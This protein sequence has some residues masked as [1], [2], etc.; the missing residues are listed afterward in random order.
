MKIILFLFLSFN[1]FAQKAA[2]LNYDQKTFDS[3]SCCWRKLSKAREFERSANLIV[4][5]L[6]NGNPSNRQS[7]NWHAGQMFAFVGDNQQALKYMDKTYNVF[8]KWFGGEDGKTWYYFAK[9]TSAFIK[10]D[11]SKLE[12]IINRWK[13]KFPVD[14]NFNELILLLKNWDLNYE[15]AT[16]KPQHS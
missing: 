13:R 14:N 4:D 3:D 9:G 5:Y 6:K 7:L 8:Q 15:T 2:C 10:R 16:K 11:K 12:K 1:L